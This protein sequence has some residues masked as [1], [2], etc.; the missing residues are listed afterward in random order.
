[1]YAGLLLFPWVLLFGL[2]GLLFNHPNVGEDVTGTRLGPDALRKVARIEPWGPGDLAR[3]ITD[4]LNGAVAEDRRLAVDPGYEPEL[5]G[6]NVFSAP[7]TDGRHLVLLDLGQGAAI[8]ATRKARPEPPTAPFAR[9]SLPL[10]GRDLR[11][12]EPQV[13]TLLRARGLETSGEL[14]AHPK[15]AQQ[16]RFRLR[17]ADGA[18]WN[19]T[20]DL[21]S[22]A[23]DGRRSDQWSPIGITQLLG[24]L[25]KTHHFT[26]RIGAQWFWALF[27]DLLGLT[28]AFWA[29]SGLVMWWQMKALRR[30]GA[31]CVAVAC[32]AGGLVIW[33]TT[34]TLTFG[35]VRQAMGPGDN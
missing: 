32:V 21:R 2:S 35:R 33:Q 15:I 4:A 6:V 16:L 1:M 28:L 14:K 23:L 17:E 13:S 25:H 18:L 10:P 29:C 24:A 20:Y 27:E 3:E 12:L 26:P 8:V 30:A 9:A 11:A 5:H 34:D 19:A 31:V 7:A 22:G